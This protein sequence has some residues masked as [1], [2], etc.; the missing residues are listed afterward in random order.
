MALDK[1]GTLK[2]KITEKLQ[3]DKA[4]EYR[5]KL[6]EERKLDQARQIEEVKKGRIYKDPETGHDVDRWEEVLKKSS[7]VINEAA[8]SNND[9]R[10]S[11]SSLISL[12]THLNLAVAQSKDELLAHVGHTALTIPRFF[13]DKINEKLSGPPDV[14]LPTLQHLVVCN[15]DNKIEVKSL[16]R[17][18]G[19]DLG[20]G[21]DKL[22]EAGVE[23]WLGDLNYQEI[24]KTG[25]WTEK[26]TGEMLTQARFNELKDDP[27]R[28]LSA[29][30]SDHFDLDLEER[31]RPSVG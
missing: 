9:W 19:D 30:L 2:K 13:Y 23:K 14:V 1:D 7:K 31:P 27:N 20:G 3:N 17:Y 6:S 15:D 5:Q 29:V 10:A 18:K 24:D 26:D 4:E 8:M 22:F 25:K 28:G 11:M 21:I 16:Q 12:F